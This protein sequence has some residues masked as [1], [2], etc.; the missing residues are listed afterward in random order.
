MAENRVT[1]EVVEVLSAD[2][3]NIR[4]TQEVVE[5]L[6]SDTPSV[7]V[8]KVFLTAIWNPAGTTPP[9]STFNVSCINT[10]IIV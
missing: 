6:S 2:S 8:S 3:S 4:A 10:P 5:V 9:S 1:Q 7:H